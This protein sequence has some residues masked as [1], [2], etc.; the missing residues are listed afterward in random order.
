M[1]TQGFSTFP[2]N[3]PLEG[4][5]ANQFDE[6]PSAFDIYEEVI[7]LDI[8]IEILVQQSNLYSQQN[9]RKF[10]TNGWKISHCWSNYIMSV[11]QLPNIPMFWDCNHFVGN[12]GI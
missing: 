9:W 6:S 11:K 7:N 4:R 12:V 1:E 10:C 2:E 3:F 5:V 8:L